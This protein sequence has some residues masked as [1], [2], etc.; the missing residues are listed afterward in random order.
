VIAVERSTRVRTVGCHGLCDE[1]MEPN[2]SLCQLLREPQGPPAHGLNFL[3]SRT[4]ATETRPAHSRSLL[5]DRCAWSHLLHTVPVLHSHHWPLICSHVA[6]CL[7]RAHACGIEPSRPPVEHFHSHSRTCRFN[8][9]QTSGSCN[10]AAGLVLRIKTALRCS[11]PDR[12]AAVPLLHPSSPRYNRSSAS[13]RAV[14]FL[15]HATSMSST[16]SS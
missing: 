15:R 9:A 2:G 1:T 3:C 7:A 11:C 16:S 6:H 4:C 13:V 14:I 8:S 10:S 5:Q 12:L